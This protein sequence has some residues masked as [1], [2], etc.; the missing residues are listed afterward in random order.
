MKTVKA[1]I[2]DFKDQVKSTSMLEWTIPIFGVCMLL[3]CLLIKS[4]S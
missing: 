1:F 3:F 4:F 2:K